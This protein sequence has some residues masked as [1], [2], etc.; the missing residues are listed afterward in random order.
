[1]GSLLNGEAWFNSD[2]RV[3]R[4]RN[5]NAV[6]SV[7]RSNNDRGRPKTTTE[8]WYGRWLRR[9]RRRFRHVAIE[10]VDRNKQ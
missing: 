4:T 1:M 8:I 5:S 7:V 2:T 10:Y 6:G 3:S 9:A